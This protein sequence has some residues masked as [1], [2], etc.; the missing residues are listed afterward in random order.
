MPILVHGENQFSISGM[1][2]T[3]SAAGKIPWS[4]IINWWYYKSVA[5]ILSAR[6][7]A[8]PAAEIK[9]SD[10]ILREQD[11][12]ATRGQDARDTTKKRT[13]NPGLRP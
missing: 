11:A 1:V 8:V 6:I 5:D 3:I 4:A 13:R 12:L 2:P 9:M 7:A 10:I